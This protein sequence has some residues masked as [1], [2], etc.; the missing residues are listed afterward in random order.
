MGEIGTSAPGSVC[1]LLRYPPVDARYVFT[2]VVLKEIRGAR[3]LLCH[4]HPP[5][6]FIMGSV[7]VT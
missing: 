3:C 7:I 6:V 1:L 4:P 5:A 2:V